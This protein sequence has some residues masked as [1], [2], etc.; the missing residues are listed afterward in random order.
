[1]TIVI[2]IA[3]AADAEDASA[4]I[5]MSF[6]EL[7]AKDWEPQAVQIFLDESSPASMRERLKAA[8]YAAGAY[9]QERLVGFILMPT[10]TL[11][12]M[13]F[14]HPQSLRRGIGRALWEAARAHIGSNFP[15]A[16]TVELNSTP[17]AVV[18]Y[19][20]LGFFPISSAF[21]RSGT[22]A[23]RMACWLPARSLGAE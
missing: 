6:L 14:V 1:M 11:L 10:P 21:Q 20:S 22:R 15:Q 5:H 3:T 16:I 18:F 19:Q 23:T 9:L 4:L 17:Y 7:A 8:T 12:G 2:R 13:L